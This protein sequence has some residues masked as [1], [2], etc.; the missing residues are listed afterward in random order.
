M[1]V[2]PISPVRRKHACEPLG[3]KGLIKRPYPVVQTQQNLSQSPLVLIGTVEIK[4][5]RLVQYKGAKLS[6]AS[7]YRA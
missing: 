2:M 7:H 4:P 5:A 1:Q 6:G 3:E